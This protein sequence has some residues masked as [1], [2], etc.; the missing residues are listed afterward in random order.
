MLPR[1]RLLGSGTLAFGWSTAAIVRR[2]TE[3]STEG[4]ATLRQRFATWIAVLNKNGSLAWPS[5][6]STSSA[7][8]CIERAPSNDASGCRAAPG[9]APD[10][11]AL[12][13][14]E[15]ERR[16]VDSSAARDG[17]MRPLPGRCGLEYGQEREDAHAVSEW[18]S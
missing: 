17:Q 8:V 12:G 3:R 4:F 14:L 18:R 11:K 10:Y 5:A 9:R 15:P 6:C 16:P 1:W 2:R 7:E 13:R